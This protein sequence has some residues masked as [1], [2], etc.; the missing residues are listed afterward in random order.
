MNHYRHIIWDWNGTLFDDAWLCLEIMNRQL[1]KRGLPGLTAE[2]YQQIFDFPVID[3][4]R[5]L[6]FDFSV[7]PFFDISTEFILAYEQRRPECGLRP[8]AL[9]V[10]QRNQEQGISQSILSASKQAHL[11]AALEQFGI[12]DL[13]VAVAGLEDHHAFGKVETGHR[14]VS[15]LNLDRDRTLLI[16][17]TL[18]DYEV[19][20]AIGVDCCLVP[21]GHQAPERLAASGVRVVPALA[22]LFGTAGP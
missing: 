17:D 3:Y 16:G 5:Q 7:E 1:D 10:L 4:Y 14:L 22:D 2:R 6:G 11:E 21:G 9:A 18:H 8:E 12:R 20:Q 19:A 13:F 15:T